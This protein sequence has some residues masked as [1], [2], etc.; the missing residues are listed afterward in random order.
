MEIPIPGSVASVDIQ[1]RLQPQ[2]LSIAAHV[3]NL[4]RFFQ[5]IDEFGT[6]GVQFGNIRVLEAVLKFRAAHAVFHRKI[7]HRLHVEFDVLEFCHC[8]LEAANYLFRTHMALIQRFQVYH[9][10]AGVQRDIGPVNSDERG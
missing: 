7:L 3:A 4:R 10:P 2:V 9:D 8:R 5:G 6:P 1:S